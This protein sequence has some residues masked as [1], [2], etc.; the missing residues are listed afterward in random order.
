MDRLL[1]IY[2]A[3]FKK[4][5]LYE[6]W[7]Q[8]TTVVLRKPGKP[9]YNMPKAYRLIALLDTMWKVLTAIVVDHVTFVTETH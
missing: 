1:S 9:K 4:G 6:P 7:K 2:R 5:L 3:I 8:S